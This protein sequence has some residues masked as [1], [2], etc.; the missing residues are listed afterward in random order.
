MEHLESGVNWPYF[1]ITDQNSEFLCKISR[2]IM[3]TFR[4]TGVELF[5]KIYQVI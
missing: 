1:Q 5:E 4:R 3:K 2:K